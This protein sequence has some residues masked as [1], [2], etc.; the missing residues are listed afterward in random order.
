MGRNN[1][2]DLGPVWNTAHW[3]IILC[4]EKD[5]LPVWFGKAGKKSA[6]PEPKPEPKEEKKPDQKPVTGEK[7]PAKPPEK[8]P[9]EIDE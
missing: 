5:N 4:L 2:L 6:K 8:K 9:I 1:D 3:T 7:P